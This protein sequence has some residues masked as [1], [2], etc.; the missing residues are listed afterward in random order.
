MRMRELEEKTGVKREMIHFYLRNGMLPEPERPRPRTAIY[1]DQHVTAIKSIRQL[2][3]EERLKIDE[4]KQLLQGNKGR[5]ATPA[6]SFRH[7]DELFASHAGLDQELVPL[8]EILDR[9]PKAESDAKLFEAMGAIEL[10]KR[11]GKTY[12]SH[13]DAEIV[14]AWGD[15][16]AAGATEEIGIEP[17]LLKLHVELAER[18]A[19]GEVNY[20]LDRV[21]PSLSTERKAEIAHKGAKV[22]LELFSVLRMKAAIKAFAVVN[23]GS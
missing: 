9:N 10:L 16:R 19:N 1:N 23:E 20:F 8:T 21:P 7:L 15:M 14:G 3:T 17:T 22:I 13:V 18:L 6:A 12:L 11:K 2:Q 4:I 5:I